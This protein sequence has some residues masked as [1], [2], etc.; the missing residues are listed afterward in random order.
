M[1][2]P[3]GQREPKT[4]TLRIMCQVRSSATKKKGLNKKCI[5]SEWL[6]SCFFFGALWF[7][8]V[9]TASAKHQKD[10]LIKNIINNNSAKLGSNP[11]YVGVQSR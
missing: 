1:K 6:I 3:F 10:V 11:D 9:S 8:G 5:P 7:L 2:V 4:E